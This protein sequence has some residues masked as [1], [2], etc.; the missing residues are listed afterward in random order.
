MRKIIYLHGFASSGCSGTVQLL[1]AR[2]RHDQVLAPDIPLDPAEGL[3]FLRRFCA[4][5][6]PDLI[7]GTSMGG[8]YGHQMRGHL[9]IC[10]NPALHMSKIYSVLKPGRFTWLNKRRDGEREGKVTPAI[11]A[12]FREMEEHQFDGLDDAD[13]RLCWGLFGR[14]DPIVHTH[15][16]FAERYL[17]EQ[18]LWFDG[19]HRL[20]D[21]VVEEAVLPLI[22]RLLPE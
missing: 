11:I 10:I 21:T 19:E 6:Q 13:R 3:P 4:E 20:N 1:R 8:L 16:E 18:A 22:R 2:F 15:D 17:P 5:E 9:R 14:S 12:H 7:V